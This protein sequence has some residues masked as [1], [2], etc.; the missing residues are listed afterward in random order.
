MNTAIGRQT[1]KSARLVD[2]LAP[3]STFLTVWFGQMV[4]LLGSSMTGFALGVWI[5]Q[6]T[7]SATSFALI[8]LANMLPKAVLAPFAGVAADRYNRRIIMIAT[9][10]GAGLA[11]VLVAGLF[12]TGNMQVWHIYLLTAINASMGALQGPA[13]GASVTQLVPKAQLGRANGL[14]QL[15]GGVS[16]IAA[17][18]LAGVLMAISGLAAVLLIDMLS[19]LFAVGV[20]LLVRFPAVTSGNEAEAEGNGL[21]WVQ[22]I[23]QGVAYL[24]ERPGLMGLVLVFSAVNF[25]VGM[26]EA[27]LTP[28]VL[29]FT[30]ADRL[31]VIMTIGGVGMLAGSI[32]MSV[33]GGGKRKVYAVFG[34]YAFLSLGVLLAGVAPSIVVITVAVFLAFFFLPIVMSASQAIM[35]AKVPA[36]IQG[37]VFS[38]EMML[39]TL[40]FGLAFL[41]A[42]FLA[43][44]IFEPLMAESGLLT[45]SVGLIIGS[46]AGRG[47][48]LMFVLTGI[49]A[50]AVATA[51]LLNPRIRNVDTEVPDAV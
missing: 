47:M 13:F 36:N 39:H 7:G 23:L 37:R 34:A 9:D 5:Y 22:Q 42:G 32:L 19:F 35:Q 15:G 20:L 30:T 49:L 48:G 33:W 44:R 21:S 45:G 12:I 41:T 11:T 51:A 28:L 50:L 25:F 26:A 18:V 46:G 10:L 2:R 1:N 24:R 40:A 31:G 29:S 8:L 14:M 3:F 38:F 27:V 4:S 43:D 17:P 6:Q 16:Q